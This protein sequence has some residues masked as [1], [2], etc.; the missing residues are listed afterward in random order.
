MRAI[1]HVSLK[2]GVLDPQGRAVADALGRLGFDTVREARVGKTIELDLADGLSAEAAE[3][4]VK[5]M[6]EKLLANPVI[7]RFRVEIA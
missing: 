5:A 6:C 3:A 2:P 1:V 7:E 4:Q